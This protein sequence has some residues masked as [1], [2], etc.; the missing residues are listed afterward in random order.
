MAKIPIN[1]SLVT[2]SVT[3]NI[4]S[5]VNLNLSNAGGSKDYFGLLNLQTNSNIGI[6]AASDDEWSN[7]WKQQQLGNGG[8]RERE[9]HTDPTPLL[10]DVIS[11]LPLNS[12]RR[13]SYEN[14]KLTLDGTSSNVGYGLDAMT[15]ESYRDLIRISK[16]SDMVR[17]GM[18]QPLPNSNQVLGS[19]EGLLVSN[20]QTWQPHFGNAG[21]RIS[22]AL[23]SHADIDHSIAKDASGPAAFLPTA[24]IDL[25][26]NVSS[27]VGDQIEGAFKFTQTELMKHLPS[28]VSGSLRQLS[29]GL[30]KILSVPFEIASDVY[31]GLRRLM[32]EVSDLLDAAKTKIIKWI[33]SSLGGLI[34]G[35]FPSGLLDG[36][37]SFISKIAD[38]FG[39]LFDLFGGFSVVASIKD[40]FSNIISGNF[41]GALKSAVNLGKLLLS[42]ISSASV[43]GGNSN[44]NIDCL[45]QQIGLNRFAGKLA[46]AVVAG[47]AIQGI[48]QSLPLIGKG[49]GNL[50]SV[51]INA[52]KGIVG[53][54]FSSVRN[55]GGIIAGLLPGAL[56]FVLGKLFAKFCGVGMVGNRGYS[57]GA[58]FD[59]RR[60]RSFTTAMNSYASHASIVG[61]L[62]NKQTVRR[63]SYA[64]EPSLS[65]FENSRFVP[66]AQGLNGVTMVGPGGSITFRP[67][68]IF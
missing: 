68:G 40:V 18:H 47:S 15:T 17:L 64:A 33:I 19:E 13:R 52:A 46:N 41:L 14:I 57:I 6:T 25:I 45:E 60:D 63:G 23:G 43:L 29:T 65:F 55:L 9:H 50:G 34:D 32:S 2:T 22:Y 7:A 27:F 66:G 59:N 28:K 53:T 49:L 44:P 51:L 58:T 12:S 54:I 11:S 10:A 26:D 37:V 8:T 3:N 56:K 5:T 35:L 21:R 48:L 38:E 67:F 36:F 24:C 61:P 20:I 62:F 39:D 1:I 30:D 42:G 4:A 31:N 16:Q